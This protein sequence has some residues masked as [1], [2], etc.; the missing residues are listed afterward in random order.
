MIPDITT[1]MNFISVQQSLRQVFERVFAEDA[2][3]RHY[4]LENKSELV[5]RTLFQNLESRPAIQKMIKRSIRAVLQERSL[6]KP[7]LIELI[8][9]QDEAQPEANYAVAIRLLARSSEDMDEATRIMLLRAVWRKVFLT[10]DWAELQNTAGL[11]D[12]QINHRLRE[13]RL[14]ATLR[15]TVGREDGE[16]RMTPRQAA[17]IPTLEELDRLWPGFNADLVEDLLEDYRWEQERLDHPEIGTLY[18][19]I[20]TLIRHDMVEAE[21]EDAMVL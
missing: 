5:L 18:E 19:Q 4:N 20:D 3:T 14:Y 8:S 21:N 11:S 15:D 12:A 13:T 16:E 7:D 2:T 17:A 10:V 9:S 1:Q 6:D